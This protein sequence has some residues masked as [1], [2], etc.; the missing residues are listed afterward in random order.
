M[1]RELLIEVAHKTEVPRRALHGRMIN[2]LLLTAWQIM[3]GTLVI[4]FGTRIW[5]PRDNCTPTLGY[6]HQY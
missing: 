3:T 1:R 6:R 4:S 2:S 5:L